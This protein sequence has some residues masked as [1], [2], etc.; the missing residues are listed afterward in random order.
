MQNQ[1]PFESIL[2]STL[3]SIADKDA[4]FVNIILSLFLNV[5]LLITHVLVRNSAM[6]LIFLS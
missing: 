2:D 1:I 3:R 4:S 6:W 5:S